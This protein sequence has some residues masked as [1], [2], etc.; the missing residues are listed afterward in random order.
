ME[1][2]GRLFRN[3]KL[4]NELGD[5]ETRVRAVW[6]RAAG[7][8]VAAHTRAGVM[9]RRTLIV[10]VEDNVWQQQLFR[11]KGFLVSNLEKELGEKLVDDIDFRPMPRRREPQRAEHS[12]GSIEGIEDP[13]LALLYQ[14]S[15]RGAS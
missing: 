3:V 6:V 5:P 4:P 8:I 14:R 9:V 12:R 10:E 13:V 7:K 15:R 1:R 11:L 2:A